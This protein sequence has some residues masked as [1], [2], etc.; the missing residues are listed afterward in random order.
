MSDSRGNTISGVP[1]KVLSL[2]MNFRP[3]SVNNFLNRFSGS[4]A[5]GIFIIFPNQS[6]F[7]EGVHCQS[8][9]GMSFNFLTASKA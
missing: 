2:Q 7:L 5:F 3:L 1:S 9:K 8:P 4:E 6:S